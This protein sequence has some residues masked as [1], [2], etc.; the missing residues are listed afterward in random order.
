[1]FRVPKAYTLHPSP[2][3]AKP[4]PLAMN[5]EWATGFQCPKLSWTIPATSLWNVPSIYGTFKLYFLIV[6][7]VLDI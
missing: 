5:T 2:V 7:G 6:P 3:E 4:N 1:M